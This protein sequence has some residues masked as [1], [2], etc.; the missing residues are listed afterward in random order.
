[1]LSLHYVVCASSPHTTLV[2]QRFA[3]QRKIL[4]GYEVEPQISL[5][6]EQFLVYVALHRVS[7]RRLQ[8]LDIDVVGRLC[9]K[10][11]RFII[12]RIMDIL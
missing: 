1:M 5:L 8:F 7:L 4:L 11:Y 6:T 10:L 12:H 9:G 2:V 3:Y